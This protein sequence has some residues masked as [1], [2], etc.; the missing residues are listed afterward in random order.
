MK[1]SKYEGKRID[2]I[3]CLAS[4]LGVSIS[5]LD[6][7]V[8]RA[9]RYYRF[10]PIKKPNGKFRETYIVEATLEEIHEGIKIQILDKVTYPPYLWGGIIGRNYIQDASLH[11]GS[12]VIIRED[13]LDFYPSISYRTV[14][15]IFE[16]FFGFPND[17]AYVLA[18]LITRKG[19]IPQGAKTSAHIANL[20]FWDIEPQV[21]TELENRG[22]RYSRFVDDMT[23][24]SIM[25]ISKE[26]ISVIRAKLYGMLRVKGLEPNPEKSRIQTRALATQVHGLNLNAGRPTMPKPERARIRLAVHQCEQMAQCSRSGNEYAALY[27]QTLGR[28]INMARLHRH[29]A[30]DYLRRLRVIPPILET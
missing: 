21:E 11:A 17:V 18:R 16:Q 23:T 29:K 30:D 7:I 1:S 25:P 24:S 5:T 4:I 15:E 9:D 28:V 10:N 3:E 8:V 2:S 12:Y 26:D 19:F 20:V 13:I 6:K 14:L 22:L 27:K